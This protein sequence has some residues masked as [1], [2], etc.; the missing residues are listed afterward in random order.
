MGYST[1]DARFSGSGDDSVLIDMGRLRTMEDVDKRMD[2]IIKHHKSKKRKTN[3][4][5]LINED[6]DILIK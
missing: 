2:E 4:Q 6:E 5:P 1:P 3:P